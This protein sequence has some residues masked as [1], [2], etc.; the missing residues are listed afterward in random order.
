MKLSEKL[1]ALEDD[2]D[3]ATPAA[4]PTKS[5]TN[6][7]A[8]HTP[9]HTP[10]NSHA[11]WEASKRE[12]RA[13]VL[14]D[15]APGMAGLDGEALAAEV[16]A[17]VDKFLTREDVKVGPAERRRF[18]E[19]VIQDTLGYGALEPLLGDDSVTEIMCNGHD[20]I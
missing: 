10:R 12:L 6:T 8:A 17:C 2:D 15:L 18:V 14:A 5:R 20:E 13:L 16:K 7:K 19:E 1:A 4:T 11:S 3:V 9:A